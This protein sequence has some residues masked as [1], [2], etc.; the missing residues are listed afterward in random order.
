MLARLSSILS[1]QSQMNV[2]QLSLDVLNVTLAIDTYILYNIRLILL[3]IY[4]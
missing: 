1:F 3:V 4:L 2:P